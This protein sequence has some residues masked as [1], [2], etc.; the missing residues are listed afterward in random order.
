MLSYTNAGEVTPTTCL[1][2]C[3]LYNAQTTIS[4]FNSVATKSTAAPAIKPDK[5]NCSQGQPDRCFSLAKVGQ[6]LVCHH[7]DSNVTYVYSLYSR[8]LISDYHHYLFHQSYGPQITQIPRDPNINLIKFYR[9]PGVVIEYLHKSRLVICALGMV[10]ADRNRS[11]L[12]CCIFSF[13]A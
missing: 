7:C 6:S 13:R 8:V 1:T 2:M 11:H 4:K 9:F 10:R 3:M 5:C 12:E